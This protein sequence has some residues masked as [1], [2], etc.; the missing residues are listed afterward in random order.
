MSP[1]ESKF[2]LCG[3]GLFGL[4]YSSEKLAAIKFLLNYYGIPRLAAR[5]SVMVFL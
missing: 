1:F 5:G 3:S 2:F 4:G